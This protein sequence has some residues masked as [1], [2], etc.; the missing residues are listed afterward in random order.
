MSDEIIVSIISGAFTF[1]GVI[2][3]VFFS[4]KKTRQDMKEQANLTNYRIEQLEIKQDKHNK[5]IERMY[6]AEDNI[7]VLQEKEKV[8]DHRIEDL[9]GFH[10]P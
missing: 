10:R 6:K 8:Q 1:A 4:N 3:T 7:H 9:E 2:L 5:I